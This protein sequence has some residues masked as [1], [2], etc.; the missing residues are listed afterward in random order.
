MVMAGGCVRND[1]D[2]PEGVDLEEI[3][4]SP[5]YPPTERSNPMAQ[6]LFEYAAI[7]TPA[8]T[9]EE[10]ERGVKPKSELIVPITSC[11]ANNEKEAMMLAS[12]ALPEKYTDKLE[13]VEIAVRPF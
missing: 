4:R 12:R 10:M 7:F 13:Q 3:L 2:I 1:W 5:W 11:L 8:P 6:K 9:K